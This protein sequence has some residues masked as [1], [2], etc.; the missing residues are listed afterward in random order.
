[1]RKGKKECDIVFGL[2]ARGEELGFSPKVTFFF[3]PWTSLGLA[4][5][6]PSSGQ[7][8]RG[9]SDSFLGIYYKIT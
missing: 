1:M 8:S 5:V 3:Y 7:P 6:P 9:G 4:G 2:R